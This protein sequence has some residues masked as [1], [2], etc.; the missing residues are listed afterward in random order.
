MN[1]FRLSRG[2]IAAAA[3][4]A[5]LSCPAVPLPTHGASTLFDLVGATT[6]PGVLVQSSIGFI[7]QGFAPSTFFAPAVGVPFA[8]FNEFPAPPFRGT[9]AG[10]AIGL[11][12]Y[13][14]PPGLNVG[15]MACSFQDTFA[16]P[17]PDPNT[18]DPWH[19]ESKINNPNAGGVAFAVG[20]FVGNVPL[21][22]GF[23]AMGAGA[24]F[25]MDIDMHEATFGLAETHTEPF[26]LTRPPY[27]MSFI[28][29]IGAGLNFDASITED[30][31]AVT[32]PP[33]TI[34]P[35]MGGGLPINPVTGLP[36]TWG[37]SVDPPTDSFIFDIDAARL[38][39]PLLGA[40]AGVPGTGSGLR[41]V[42]LRIPEP[43]TLAL[44]MLAAMLALASRP[45]N[46]RNWLVKGPPAPTA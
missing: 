27:F 28:N 8:P 34:I 21:A 9:H 24:S 6:S 26:G 42:A 25:L 29:G 5:A 1:T 44:S 30:E 35:G 36:T 43:A 2:L 31:A 3:L 15:A 32:V 14:A 7:G 41:V 17:G 10:C 23:L 46:A 13:I 20:W 18:P 4:C 22:A 40:G 38:L 39:L 45:R 37:F 33:G 11:G 12:F 19:W 16:N